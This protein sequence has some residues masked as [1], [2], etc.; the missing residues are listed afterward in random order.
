MRFHAFITSI[1]LSLISVLGNAE[2]SQL[3]MGFKSISC[4][5]RITEGAEL[6]TNGEG[7]AYSIARRISNLLF[8]QDDLSC[9]SGV[10]VISPE[11]LLKIPKLDVGDEP[12][13]SEGALLGESGLKGAGVP[14]SRMFG[15]FR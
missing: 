10:D 7:P 9:S 13:V 14:K 12:D 6:S 2:P 4:F 1:F 15:G 3:T 11:V 5:F 8:G